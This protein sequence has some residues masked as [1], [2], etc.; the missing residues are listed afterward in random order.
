[1]N[2]AIDEVQKKLNITIKE[3]TVSGFV[4]EGHFA[5]RWYIGCDDSVNRDQV[6]QLIDQALCQMNDDYAVERESA[7]K[8][9]F[10]EIL[11]PK[12]F[13]DFCNRQIR[14]YE[15]VPAGN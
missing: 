4:Y 7:L 3:F 5:H 8:Q 14:S 12:V 1:M 6:V 2:K 10:I 15:Q 13:I 9:V 11:P